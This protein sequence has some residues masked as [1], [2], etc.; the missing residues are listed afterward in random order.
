MD[1]GN[2]DEEELMERYTTFDDAIAG[3]KA[4]VGRVCRESGAILEIGDNYIK[5]R[6]PITPRKLEYSNE[7]SVSVLKEKIVRKVIK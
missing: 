6:P 7:T 4:M 1:L 2:S 5:K 3:H